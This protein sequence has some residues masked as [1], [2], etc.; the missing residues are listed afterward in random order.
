LAFLTERYLALGIASQAQTAV[1]VLEREFP[2]ASSTIE[3]SNA[4]RSVGLAPAENEKSWIAAAF[5]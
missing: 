2:G 4:L 5:R 3:A 1:A